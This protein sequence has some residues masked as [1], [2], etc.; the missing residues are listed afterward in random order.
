MS[1][2]RPSYPP[3]RG[4]R[5]SNRNHGRDRYDSRQSH[6]G[7]PGAG[8]SW[9]NP[10]PEDREYRRRSRSRSPPRHSGH[11]D[12]YR[13]GDTGRRSGGYDGY[14]PDSRPPQGDF[15]FRMDKPSG[16][17]DIGDSY[18]PGQGNARRNGRGRGR[19]GPYGRGRG[20]YQKIIPA[21]RE[22]LK[23]RRDGVD[24]NLVNDADGGAK[25]R[26]IDELSDDEEA[27][28]DISDNSDDDSG[29]PS[30]KRV[31]RDDND[32]SGNSVP[33]W[34]N[35]DP[36]TA[37]P[38]PDADKERKKKDMVKMIRKARVDDSAADKLAASTEAEEFISFDMDGGDD[39]E[40]EEIILPPSKSPTPPPPP[41]SL[42]APPP[43]PPSLPAA[44]VF[45][46][47]PTAPRNDQV[48][49]GHFNA[50]AASTAPSTSASNRPALPPK[51][52]VADDAL[53]SRKRT[54]DDQIKPPTY[55]P[56][57][58]V[59]KMPVGGDILPEWQ[60]TRH[61][62]PTPWIKAD[63]SKSSDM[64]VWLHKE[65]VDFYEMVRPR[66]FEHA[67]RSRLVEKL[68]RALRTSRNYRDHD[69]EPF[70]SFMSGLYLPT[71]DMDLVV[72]AKRWINGGPSEF[73]GMKPLRNFG[74]FLSSCR[75]SNYSTM[76]FIG[77][78]KVPL[79]KYIDT[80]TGLRVDIS[81][82]RLDGPQA[83]KTF[84]AWKEQYPAMP[85]LVTMIKHFLV[86]RG[87]NE[88]VNGG[89]GSFTVTCMVV[90]MLQLM[91]QVQSRNLVPEHHLGEMLM[92]FFDLYGNRFDYTN[93]AIRLNPPGYMHK[94]K[95]PDVVYKN[96][97]R[98]SVIDPNNPA[99]DISGGSSNAGRILGEFRYAYQRLQKR[100][101]ELSQLGSRA[102]QPTSIL[103]AI[104]AGNYS[105]FRNQRA[106]LRR[107]HD[108]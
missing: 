40:E 41:P 14:R 67:M 36:Y 108:Q 18:R 101:A 42:P 49:N 55:G 32:E 85:I 103:E 106:H 35:P 39:G 15:T 76:E 54:V 51:P 81:F 107:L 72:C 26:D 38:P 6:Q 68:R 87:L 22:L 17:G 28:M 16:V 52:V 88:P 29:E 48:S 62:D 96:R 30:N 98:L 63:H 5:D 92:E 93:T 59:N 46:E 13:G 44:A 100:M 34:S 91:P 80:Q 2:Y 71:A 86:M 58:K 60:I 10:W 70:G 33:K 69:L 99:N 65:V 78:A 27:D 43:P 97:D 50:S 19:G 77:H 21:E 11:Y 83:I 75:I 94:T 89:I 3:R 45:R 12:S 7:P 74:K 64:S 8:D 82:D 25:Y 53:G 24:E 66:E 37:L 9:R 79:V 57:R 73:F 90:S 1:S 31:R 47:P 104:Y 95:V 4:N 84:A 20:G 105:S 102:S 23:S 56:L 61:E